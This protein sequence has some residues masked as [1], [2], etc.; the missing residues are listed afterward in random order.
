MADGK[1]VLVVLG[2]FQDAERAAAAS[3][4]AKGTRVIQATVEGRKMYRVVAGPFPSQ[5][6]EAVRR[7]A[8]D[9]AWLLPL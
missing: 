4:A 8:S 6:A 1:R 9:G 5:Q 2:S 3:N 7:G